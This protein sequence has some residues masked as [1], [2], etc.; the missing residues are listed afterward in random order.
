MVVMH[1][2]CEGLCGRT[3]NLPAQALVDLL[4]ALGPH[5]VAA[6]GGLYADVLPAPAA[7]PDQARQVSCLPFQWK[8]CWASS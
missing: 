1:A 7:L 5:S 3:L 6:P 2:A 8:C 4:E